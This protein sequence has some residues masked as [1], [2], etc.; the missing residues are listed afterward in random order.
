MAVAASTARREGDSVNRND[1]L[2]AIFWL[3][4]LILLVGFVIWLFRELDEENDASVGVILF[5]LPLL[6]MMSVG[7]GGSA[8]VGEHGAG[9]D[10]PDEPVALTPTE[11]QP[12]MI[13]FIVGALPLIAGAI[14][15]LAD[16]FTFIPD[17]LV[18][19][20][21]VLGTLT[22]GLAALWAR[23]QV[24]PL[25]DPKDNDGDPLTPDTPDEPPL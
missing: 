5:G 8:H 9:E 14:S 2:R 6:G 17:W 24:T 10:D 18:P 20:L 21:L 16:L 7:A 15:S 4:F 22:S 23:L 12:V 25:A 19:T 3:V 11:R 1:P 13:A